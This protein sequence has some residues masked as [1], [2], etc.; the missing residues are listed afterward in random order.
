MQTGFT[1]QKVTANEEKYVEAQLLAIEGNRL[2]AQA[3]ADG[4]RDL[5]RRVM[6]KL[7]LGHRRQ[8]I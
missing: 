2:I 8:P 1:L 3:I 5:R 7:T 6:H 4:L